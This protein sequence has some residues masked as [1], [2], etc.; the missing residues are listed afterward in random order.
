MVGADESTELWW[1]PLKIYFSPFIHFT[2]L[3]ERG[4]VSGSGSASSFEKAALF[5]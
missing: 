1:P 5:L 3:V 2:A 4:K